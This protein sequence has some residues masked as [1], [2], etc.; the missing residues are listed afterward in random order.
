MFANTE[1]LDLLTEPGPVPGG[2]P[3]ISTVVTDAGT[4]ETEYVVIACGV[5][6]NRVANMA[7]AHIPLVPAVH[8]MADVG[9]VDVLVATG[10]EIG[11]PIVRDMDTFCY[12]RQSAGSMEVG[13]YAHRPIFY[14]PD[15]IPDNDTAALSPRRCRSLPTTSTRRWSRPSS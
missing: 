3:R 2:P 5:W 13:S 6:S 4:I 7:G 15:D 11:Y 1:V 9:P 10:N 8:Q 14:H 12:E